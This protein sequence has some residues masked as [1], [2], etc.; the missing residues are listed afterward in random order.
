M[1]R[2]GIS[3]ISELSDKAEC[4]RMPILAR[5]M[6]GQL[7]ENRSLYVSEHSSGVKPHKLNLTLK[8]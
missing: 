4:G 1:Q 5:Y 8:N 6:R 2:D 7:G 3:I